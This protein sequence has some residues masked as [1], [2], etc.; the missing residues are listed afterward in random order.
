MDIGGTY[1]TGRR[2]R[3]TPTEPGKKTRN[4]SARWHDVSMDDKTEWEAIMTGCIENEGNLIV[5]LDDGP[6]AFSGDQNRA[7]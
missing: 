7:I 6:G 2:G 4:G 3:Y 5:R 1:E